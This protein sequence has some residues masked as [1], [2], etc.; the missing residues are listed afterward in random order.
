M[1]ALPLYAGVWYFLH[2]R[3]NRP[4]PWR[5]PLRLSGVVRFLCRSR[6][7]FSSPLATKIPSIVLN[8]YLPVACLV[9]AYA[10]GCPL[11]DIFFLEQY[12]IGV[13]KVY[14]SPPLRKV[15]NFGVFCLSFIPIMHYILRYNPLALIAIPTIATAWIALALQDTLK[16]FIAGV[17][18]GS[19]VRVGD[20]IAYQDKE[21]AGCWIWTGRAPS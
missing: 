6:C 4:F 9:A 8:A 20:W 17:G 19:L 5:T 7:L 11:V 18:L 13:R 15:I 14:I 10:A 3:K 21:D 1:L 2:R 12:L 16:A